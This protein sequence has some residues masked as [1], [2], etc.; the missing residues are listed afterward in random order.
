VIDQETGLSASVLSR[1]DLITA[2]LAAGRPQDLADMD[3]DAR[4]Q[5][6]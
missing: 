5:A 2:K 6:G 4:F 3:K 1:A